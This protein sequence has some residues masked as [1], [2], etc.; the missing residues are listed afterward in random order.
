MLATRV[1]IL[2]AILL[3]AAYRPAQVDSSIWVATQNNIHEVSRGGT[4]AQSYPA[5]CI[6]SF[7]PC[8]FSVARDRLGNV[9]IGR[10]VAD[11]SS[12]SGAVQVYRSGVGLVSQTSLPAS[13][14]MVDAQERVWFVR[15]ATGLTMV[16]DNITVYRATPGLGFFTGSTFVQHNTGELAPHSDGGAWLAAGSTLR[17]ISS[18]MVQGPVLG[19]PGPIEKITS[20]LSDRLWV[21][22]GGLTLD[23]V[24]DIGGGT[25]AVDLSIP[26]AGIESIHV[27][28]CGVLHVHVQS[29]ISTM[30]RIAQDGSPMPP[31][32]FGLR[33]RTAGLGTGGGY[34]FQHGATAS[35]VQVFSITNEGTTVQYL[36]PAS[37]QPLGGVFL[38]GDFTGARLA[39]LHRGFYDSDGD[40]VLDGEEAR[41]GSDYF[42]A[43]SRPPAVAVTLLQ[44]SPPTWQLAY[45]DP[46]PRHA[47]FGY[48]LALSRTSLSGFPVGLGGTCPLVPLDL[49]ELF[50]ASLSPTPLLSGFGGSLDA[51][52]SAAAGIALPLAVASGLS[53]QV[54]G[55]T[56]APG[57][58]AIVATS[59]STALVTP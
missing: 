41:R 42:L 14:V 10:E 53:F 33:F 44:V 48:Q 24:V 30:H 37:S 36:E 34:W 7:F 43:P 19:F 28:L 58:G 8:R 39:A 25:L 40:F 35:G 2:A 15:P 51:T 55:V 11:F 57:I 18:T 16:V 45:M 46:D 9:F 26:F 3:L 32:S 52:G 12:I 49:D 17:R 54:A 47:N 5:P 31:V 1:P 23:R 56:V 38:Q 13:D 22:H 4:L 6:S 50:L 21:W 20:D 27:D 59:A 29:G